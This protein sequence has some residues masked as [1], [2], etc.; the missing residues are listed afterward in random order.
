LHMFVRAGA[1]MAQALRLRVRDLVAL[2][3]CCPRCYWIAYHLDLPYQMPFPKV[4]NA[5]DAS[6]K[7]AIRGHLDR[8]GRL[9]AWFPWLGPVTAYVPPDRL[10][11]SVFWIRDPHTG[12]V[13]VG[14][15][16]DVFWMADGSYHIVDYKTTKPATQE[17][18]FPA[19]EIQLNAYAYIAQ[20][21]GLAPV[22][23]LSLVY[24]EPRRMLSTRTGSHAALVFRATHRSVR[25]DP[26][27]IV[28]PLVQ[29]ASAILSCPAP[30]SGNSECED[31]R[32][33][34]R[35]VRTVLD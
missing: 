23:G 13:L 32:R 33:L 5:I 14:S 1:E 16:D 35:L 22:S 20:R 25:C 17:E 10:H 21:L 12:I 3:G 6:T 9:P 26:D 28:P 31:C 8:H 7:N 2:C 19:Y 18:L 24:L 4:F 15:P 34:T 11:W 29:Q 27:G 30:P